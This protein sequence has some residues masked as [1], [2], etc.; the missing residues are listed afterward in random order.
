LPGQ[1]TTAWVRPTSRTAQRLRERDAS[2]TTAAA[3][4]TSLI[5]R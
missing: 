1:R 5:N 4:T 3:A 2:Q